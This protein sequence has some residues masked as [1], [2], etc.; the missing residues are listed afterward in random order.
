MSLILLIYVL[1]TVLTLGCL[2]Y[3]MKQDGETIEEFISMAFWAIV[4]LINIA[5][6]LIGIAYVIDKYTKIGEKWD[7]FK[8]RK[9]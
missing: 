7:E 9:L 1:P 8:K 5:F 6:M 4:P 3:T 2:Y